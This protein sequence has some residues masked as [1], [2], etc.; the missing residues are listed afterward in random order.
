MTYGP[1][2]ED[3]ADVLCFPEMSLRLRLLGLVPLTFFILNLIHHATRQQTEEILWLC[4]L[5]NL[6]LAIGL[7]F[8]KPVLLRIAIL[9]L[10]PGFPLWL[11]ESYRNHDLPFSS[12]LAHFGALVLGLFFLPRIGMRRRTWLPAFAYALTIQQI[13]R[14]V[15]PPALNINVAFK[16]YPGWENILDKYWKFWVFISLEAAAFLFLLALL[17]SRM[18]PEKPLS[19]SFSE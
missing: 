12:I 19:D 14:W 11:I 2:T 5:D 15:T 10:I 3:E 16:M 9:W 7:I 13:S 6:L 8:N 17:L 1:A 4:N 18:F